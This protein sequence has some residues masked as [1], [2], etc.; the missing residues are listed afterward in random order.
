MAT[1]SSSLQRPTRSVS[2]SASA[3]ND[4]NNDALTFAWNLGDGATAAGAAVTHTYGAVG[5][6]TATVT[7][8]DAAGASDSATVVV[9]IVAASIG[10]PGLPPADAP[11]VADSDGDG[12]PD[13]IEQAAG[14][15][16]TNNQNTPTE[17][18]R[19]R[20][21]PAVE[22]REFRNMIESVGSTIGASGKANAVM[23]NGFGQLLV[24]RAAQRSISAFVAMRR[25]SSI[26]RAT[27]F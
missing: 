4:L 2:Q 8:T 26:G 14:T 25:G 1:R 17:A 6:Y 27:D 11:A 13:S 24:P 12:F 22:S 23:N 3:A 20:K 21:R 10:G 5:T 18:R 15:S 9:T 16:P 7:V 19:E